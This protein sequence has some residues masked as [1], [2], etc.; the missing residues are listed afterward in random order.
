MDKQTNRQTDRQRDATEKIPS[1][2]FMSVNETTI[3]NSSYNE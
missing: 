2:A 1:A 3:S